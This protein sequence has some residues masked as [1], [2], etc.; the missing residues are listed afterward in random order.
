MVLGRCEIPGLTSCGSRLRLDLWAR[1]V[2]HES[3]ALFPK[4]KSAAGLAL[5]CL[6]IAVRCLSCIAMK[7]RSDT[8]GFLELRCRRQAEQPRL[9]SLDLD[10]PNLRNAKEGPGRKQLRAKAT[11]DR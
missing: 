7:S 6:P 4:S 2:T 10:Q 1:P 3:P 8:P 5:H 11:G 9:S